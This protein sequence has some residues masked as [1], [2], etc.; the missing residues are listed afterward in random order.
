MIVPG[1]R[2]AKLRSMCLPLYLFFAIQLVIS[3]TPVLAS[4]NLNQKFSQ[5]YSMLEAL[6]KG[7]GS[8]MLLWFAFEFGVSMSSGEPGGQSRALKGIAGG[9]FMLVASAVAKAMGAA[10]WGL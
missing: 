5:L 4:G 9:I 8:V 6:V 3:P 1:K 7:I 10:T 2:A